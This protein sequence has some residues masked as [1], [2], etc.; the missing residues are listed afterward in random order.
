MRQQ[1]IPSNGSQDWGDLFSDVANYAASGEV[2]VILD[3][4]TWMG[5]KDPAFLSKLKIVWDGNFKNNQN[6]VLILSGSSR[7]MN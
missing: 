7:I 6:L 1:R 2:L 5:S 4:I 3:E